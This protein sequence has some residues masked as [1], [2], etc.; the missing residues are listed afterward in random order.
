MA[1]P[2]GIDENTDRLSDPDG[3]SELHEYFVSDA[4][5]DEVLRDV[6]SSIGCRAVYLRGVLAREG[7]TT[8][9]SLTSVGV[10]DDLTPR[11]TS[12]SV[13]TADDELT[14]GVD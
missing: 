4:S 6:A 14:R 9:G 10:D 5:G 8:M 11:E 12:I 7:T 2:I 1:C 13:R 3:V